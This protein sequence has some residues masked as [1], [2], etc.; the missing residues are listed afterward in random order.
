MTQT[1][2]PGGASPLTAPSTGGRPFPGR[3]VTVCPSRGRVV[4]VVRGLYLNPALHDLE[5][6]TPHPGL[7]FPGNKWLHQAQLSE[8]GVSSVARRLGGWGASKKAGTRGARD[9]GGLDLAAGVGKRPGL[10]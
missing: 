4:V 10:A 1:R 5:P 6:D 2:A 3:G 7:G 8:L 9:S